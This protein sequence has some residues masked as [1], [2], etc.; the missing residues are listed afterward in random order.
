M[1]VS[2]GLHTDGELSCFAVLNSVLM[3]RDIFSFLSLMV[4]GCLASQI[5]LVYFSKKLY[6]FCH[7]Q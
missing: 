3:D 7:H 5:M 4:S 2:Q 1:W 6:R